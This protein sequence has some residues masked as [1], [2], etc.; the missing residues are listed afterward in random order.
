MARISDHDEWLR[1][2]VI[3]KARWS[4]LMAG[5]RHRYSE[6]GRL[7][8]AE[9]EAALCA[10]EDMPLEFITDRPLADGL[11]SIE[12]T[13]AHALEEAGMARAQ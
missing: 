13:N 7:A 5:N 2:Q 12:D 4:L 1:R 8:D 11:P 6:D 3:Q 9:I 10:V